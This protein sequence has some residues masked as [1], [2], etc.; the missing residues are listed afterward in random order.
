[1]AFQRYE[2]ACEGEERLIDLLGDLQHLAHREG[3]DFAVRSPSL[4]CTSTLRPNGPSRQDLL[5]LGGLPCLTTESHMMQQESCLFCAQI[6]PPDC[7]SEAA[8]EA[9]ARP[10]RLW[11]ARHN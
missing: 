3:W 2:S 5:S 8:P 9:A 6:Y 7:E 4:R 11:Q 1:M 10:L